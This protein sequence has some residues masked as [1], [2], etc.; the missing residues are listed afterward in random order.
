MKKIALIALLGLLVL[1]VSA[2]KGSRGRYYYH[3]RTYIVS[4][5]APY[6]GYGY[7]PSY[8]YQPSSQYYNRPSKL[9]MKLEDIRN[10]YQDKI[11]S[12]RHD[13]S[14]SRAERKEIIRNLKSERNKEL[15]DT[16]A[17]YYKR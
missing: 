3:P 10:D 15:R 9:D 7:Y 4:G 1:N 17:N 13:K 5:W 2:Q 12:A 16:E 14:L 6:Y 11:R 8:W